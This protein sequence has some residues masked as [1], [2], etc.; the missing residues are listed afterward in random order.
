M[1]IYTADELANI[2]TAHWKASKE[3]I[4]EYLKNRKDKFFNIRIDDSNDKGLS[5]YAQFVYQHQI[6][7]IHMHYDEKQLFVVT[8]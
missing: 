7:N 6:Y 1:S 2:T 5:V 8:H 4:E 3:T